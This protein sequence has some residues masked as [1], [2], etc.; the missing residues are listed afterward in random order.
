MFPRAWVRVFPCAVCSTATVRTTGCEGQILT[1]LR[2]SGRFAI[3]ISKIR[4]LSNAVVR[5]HEGYKATYRSY[6]SESQGSE[7]EEH[8]A[9]LRAAEVS[10]SPHRA[11]L[12]AGW[13][14]G[15][16]AGAAGSSGTGG[17]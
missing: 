15:L 8:G 9:E 5:K 3:F 12:R 11:Q 7:Q 14:P 13:A 1:T 4:I 10:L 6:S 2:S 16:L 17:G